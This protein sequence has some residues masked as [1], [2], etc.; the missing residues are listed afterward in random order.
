M[1]VYVYKTDWECFWSPQRYVIAPYASIWSI[2]HSSSTNDFFYKLILSTK[3][4]GVGLA[5]GEYCRPS[6]KLLGVF[7]SM[8][9]PRWEREQNNIVTSFRIMMDEETEIKLY[10]MRTAKKY[11]VPNMILYIP[12][13]EEA[14]II[15]ELFGK[16]RFDEYSVQKEDIE[17]LE[18][19]L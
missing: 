5:R 19:T 7:D 8:K 4:I 14:G 3:P 2:H 17:E 15:L 1:N 12:D 18:E 13:T 11:V 10:K 6:L 9:H 16:K